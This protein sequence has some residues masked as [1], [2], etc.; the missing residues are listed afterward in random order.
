MSI[1]SEVT[2]LG[3]NLQAA[4]NA[5]T[6]KGGTVGNTGL[7]GLANEINSIPSG[8]GGDQDPEWGEVVLYGYTQSQTSISVVTPGF[9]ITVRDEQTLEDAF[10][11]SN[12]TF[13]IYVEVDG[14]DFSTYWTWAVFAA[15]SLGEIVYQLSDSSMLESLFNI[16]SDEPISGSFSL[17]FYLDSVGG[18]VIDKNNTTKRTLNSMAEFYQLATVTDYILGDVPKLALK[19]AKIGYAV[20]EIPT[21]CLRG[22]EN[23]DKVTFAKNIAVSAIGTAFCY[24]AGRQSNGIAE[25]KIPEGVTAIYDSFC[26]LAKIAGTVTL[27]STL[28]DIYGSFMNGTIVH[29]PITI[30]SGTKNIGTYFLSGSTIDCP[31][32]LPSTLVSVGT[33][34][35]YECPQMTSTV[36]ISSL[37][38]AVFATSNY[39]L[40]CTSTSYASYRVGVPIRGAR[41]ATFVSRFPNRTGNPYRKLINVG[42]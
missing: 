37:G 31:V 13:P 17:A 35:M 29:T 23:L 12:Y 7:A 30:P 22:C 26:S 28:L 3:T 19:E 25:I 9:T 33:Y 1:A 24:Q 34:F 5:V 27:P 10:S 15:D 40:S 32:T 6:S 39:T 8:G 4:K 42:A 2:A 36:N 16:Q 20:S 11:G 18:V 41:S 21:N 38:P 14:S